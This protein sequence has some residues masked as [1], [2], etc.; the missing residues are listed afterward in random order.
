MCETVLSVAG[1]IVNLPQETDE[2]YVTDVTANRKHRC[3]KRGKCTCLKMNTNTS[4]KKRLWD[5][6]V[7][8]M[9][10]IAFTFSI[11]LQE[12]VFGKYT[13]SSQMYLFWFYYYTFWLNELKR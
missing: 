4:R 12:V 2:Q 10:H 13:L 7:G 6:L 3:K 5:K 8:N 9:L 1:Q 11:V